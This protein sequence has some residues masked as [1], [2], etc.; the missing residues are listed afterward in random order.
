MLL[1]VYY[2][3]FRSN[4]EAELAAAEGEVPAAKTGLASSQDDTFDNTADVEV[5]DLQPSPA[6]DIYSFGVIMLELASKVQPT[7]DGA[8]GHEYWN[9][10]R[11]MWCAHPPSAV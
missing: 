2:M 9:N 6:A 1:Q 10:V 3:G 11:V 8:R 5:N 7:T 4:V